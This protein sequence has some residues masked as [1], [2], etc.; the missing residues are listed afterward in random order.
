MVCFFAWTSRLSLGH[1]GVETLEN[2]NSSSA[3]EI[4]PLSLEPPMTSKED[5]VLSC[6]SFLTI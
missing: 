3:K 1:G 5:F 6:D 2:G 4:L